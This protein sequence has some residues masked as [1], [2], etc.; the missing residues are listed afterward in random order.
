MQDEVRLV[1]GGRTPVSRRGDV[2]LRKASAWSSTIIALLRHLE[3]AGFA[4]APRVVGSGF[5]DQGRE[6]LGFI[7]GEFVHPGPWPDEA[8]P[9]I[10]TMLRRLHEATATFGVPK[11]AIWQPW[12]GRSLGGPLSVIGHCDTGP[13][14]IVAVNGLPTALIDWEVAGP[15]DPTFELAQ[16]CWL[17]AQ[18]HDDDIAEKVGL[19]SP[20]HRA[21]QVRLLLDGYGMARAERAGFVDKMIEFAIHD[22]ADQ[23][24]QASVSMDSRDDD[25]LWAIA[26]RTRSGRWML[27]NRAVLERAL[28]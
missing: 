25:L 18:L 13:W 3:D 10:G 14:N 6:T 26:W 12:F 24:I 11:E 9:T 17:N 27:Q 28:A 7:E 5:D 22:A 8:L 1:G 20:E 15:V 19:A 4:N 23:A 21:K 16:A 2:V